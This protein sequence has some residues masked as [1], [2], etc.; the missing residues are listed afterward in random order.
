MRVGYSPLPPNAGDTFGGDQPPPTRCGERCFRGTQPPRYPNAARDAFGEHQP[1][2]TRCWGN[3]HA[4]ESLLVDDGF[5]V[6]PAAEAAHTLVP[7]E[8]PALDLDW[9][10]D[11]ASAA[12]VSPPALVSVAAQTDAAAGALRLLIC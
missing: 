11:W 12:A 1:P 10:D 9:F 3:L 2:P 8:P 5:M 4:A 7:G 6:L